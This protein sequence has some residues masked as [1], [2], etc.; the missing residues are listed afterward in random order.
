MGRTIMVDS[1]EI[2]IY[3]RNIPRGTLIMTG[4]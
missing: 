3:M 4:T 2:N 1:I